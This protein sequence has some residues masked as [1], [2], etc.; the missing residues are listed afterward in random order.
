[1]YLGL[2][3]VLCLVGP[4]RAGFDYA[5]WNYA[6]FTMYYN[7]S[8]LDQETIGIFPPILNYLIENCAQDHNLTLKTLYRN[9]RGMYEHRM[10]TNFLYP[11]SINPERQ[12]LLHAGFPNQTFLPIISSPGM[13]F[14]QRPRP[15]N[16]VVLVLSN[17]WPLFVV[18]ILL[19]LIS[20]CV[21]WILEYKVN[22]ELFPA[23]P[24]RGIWQGS[25]W[26]VVTMTTVG[27]YT[28]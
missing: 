11:V 19:A 21:M 13:Q 15:F 2:I 17:A 16:P 22:P 4:T 28:S 12:R 25:W 5:T 10:D 1:M 3:I 8:T 23:N 9:G 7:G 6:P 18:L 26:A 20:G 14:V 27:E 24:I